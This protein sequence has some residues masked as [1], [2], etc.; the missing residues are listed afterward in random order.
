MKF[1]AR[2]TATM[3]VAFLL[4]TQLWADDTAK[5]GSTPKKDD[6]VSSR[7]APEALAKANPPG[8]TSV[9]VRLMSGPSATGVG[10]SAMS[11]SG[12]STSAGQ[13]TRG[14]VITP[15]VELFLGYSYIRATP[16]STRNR[17]AWLHGGDANIAF[18]VNHYLGLVA[19]FGGYHASSLILTGAGTPPS[20]VVD[21]DGRVFT[22][23]FGPRLSFRTHRVTPFAQALFGV[24]HAGEVSIT[25]CTGSSVCIPLPSENVFALAAG[26]GLDVN[27]HRWL[28]I[29]LIQAEYLMTRFKDP[30]SPTGQNGRRNNVRLSTGLVFRFGGNPPPPPPNRP[31]VASCSAD[32]SMVNAGSGD[33][34]A[35]RA[36][37]SDPDNDP[38]TYTWTANGGTVEGTG[39][40]VRWNSSG[41]N[42]GTYTVRVRVDDGRGGTTDCSTD[43]RVEPQANRPPVMSCSVERT[44]ILPGERTKITATASDPD[45]DPLS[46]SWR[47]SSGQII[48]SGASV[49]FDT[50]GLAPGRYTVTGRVD[51]GRGGAA[52]CSVDVDVQSPPAPAQASKLNE[53]FFRAGSARVDNVC[54]RILDDVA[55]KLK[56]EPKATVVIIG[57]A[58]PKEPRAARLAQ[59]RAELAKKYL[60]E[61]GIDESRVVTRA[62]EGQKGAGKQNGRI[63]I[64]WVPEGATY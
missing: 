47:A 18:N 44:P 26:G 56:N 27:V 25:G 6:S 51:D 36:Q 62:G 12:S 63:D 35:V 34:V 9:P 32:K 4:V 39:P 22:Y 23:L 57:F 11:S 45:N 29:R 55:L 46:Y 15:K 59:M 5:P 19:D 17:I 60:G 14:D 2:M 13:S 10:S 61:T 24:A 20:R 64:V 28:A 33:T 48:G 52:D 1:V 38:L 16:T 41:A 7:H 8:V 54:K 40:E 50:T 37:A 31:P 53:C 58:D 43:I 42:P 21:A 30:S 3:A 49:Q